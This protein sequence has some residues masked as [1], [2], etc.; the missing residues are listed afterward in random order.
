MKSNYTRVVWYVSINNS[1][2]GSGE[3]YGH[4]YRIYYSSQNVYKVG[5]RN[6]SSSTIKITCIV[7]CVYVKNNF[8][9]ELQ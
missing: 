6:L 3:S 4:V 5:V 2:S 7:R 8:V 1:T 9:Q